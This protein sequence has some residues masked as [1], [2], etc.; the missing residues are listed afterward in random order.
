[1]TVAVFNKGDFVDFWLNDLNDKTWIERTIRAK[2]WLAQDVEIYTYDCVRNSS[3]VLSFDENKNL[4]KMKIEDEIISV[5]QTY[6]KSA[7]Y[8]NGTLV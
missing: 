5:E 7:Y 4:Q 8:L 2:G 1:M 3:D 6:N